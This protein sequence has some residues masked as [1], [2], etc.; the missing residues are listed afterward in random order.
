MVQLKGKESPI[1]WARPRTFPL[2][3]LLYSSANVGGENR[4]PYLLMDREEGRM[5]G[6]EKKRCGVRME[7]RMVGRMI[8]LESHLRGTTSASIVFSLSH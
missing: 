7:F 3:I 5:G 6:G 8:Q 4:R 1:S 2:D